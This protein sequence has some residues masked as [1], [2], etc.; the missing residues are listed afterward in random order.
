MTAFAKLAIIV[1]PITAGMRKAEGIVV[2][3][4]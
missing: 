2:N 3:N 1:E 4:A